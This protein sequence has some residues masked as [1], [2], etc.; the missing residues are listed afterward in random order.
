MKP[1]TQEGDYIVF[2]EHDR[3][4]KVYVVEK[5]EDVV[6]DYALGTAL[7]GVAPGTLSSFTQVTLVQPRQV[8]TTPAEIQCYQLRVGIDVGMGY[9]EMFA[10]TIRRTPYMQRRPSAGSPYVG[11]FNQFISPYGNPRVEYFFR[12][13]EIPTFAIYNPLL[14]TINPTLSFR[15]K[16]LRLFDMDY[17]QDTA[18]ATQMFGDYGSDPKGVTAFM[19]QQKDL[20][21]K[22]KIPCR[23]VTIMGMED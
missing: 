7:G 15:G 9:V 3:P 6:M 18:N 8:T 5:T 14:Q 21:L 1:L 12:Y 16:K 2:L 10:G 13:N 22:N 11:F 23:R 20:V 17:P 4:D 19:A